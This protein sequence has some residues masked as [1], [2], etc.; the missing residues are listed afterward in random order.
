MQIFCIDSQKTEKEIIKNIKAE[1][2]FWLV[3]VAVNRFCLKSK[4]KHLPKNTFLSGSVQG[5]FSLKISTTSSH[6]GELG[7]ER[8]ECGRYGRGG[9]HKR[10]RLG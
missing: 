7:M 5:R 3:E 6:S 4:Q 8:C 9:M 1:K 10:I 2:P